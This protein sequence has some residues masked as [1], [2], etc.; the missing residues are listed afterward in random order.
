MPDEISAS[1]GFVKKKLP[2][3]DLVAAAT[4]RETAGLVD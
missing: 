2:N 1:G 3:H 4:L